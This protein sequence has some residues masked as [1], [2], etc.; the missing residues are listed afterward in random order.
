MIQQIE[1]SVGRA[2]DNRPKDV[3]LVQR[4]LNQWRISDGASIQIEE[5]GLADEETIEG[6]VSFQSKVVK[7]HH[8]DGRVDPRGATFH[9]LLE[10]NS[11]VKGG[12]WGVSA[13]GIALLKSIETLALKP[14]DDQTGKQIDHWV[15]GATIGYG[16]LIQQDQWE[17]YKDGISEQE[18]SALFQ[19]D[20]KPFAQAVASSVRVELTQ[21]QFDALVILAFNIGIANFRSSSVLKLVND[22]G[23]HTPYASLEQAWKAWNKSQGRVNE[24]LKNR[25]NAEWKIYSK[26]VYERW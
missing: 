6:I 20:L 12:Y 15:K 22:P 24:G 19:D 25:R 11:G 2:G 16:H 18:A 7:M 13:K 10:N 8:P 5:S 1:G 21:H 14:Y 4:L 23:A 17:H 3:S 9:A 26:A